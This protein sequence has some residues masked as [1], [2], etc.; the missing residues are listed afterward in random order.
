MSYDAND[1]KISQ[2]ESVW[3]EIKID[4]KSLVTIGV[5]YKSQATPDYELRELFKVL[6]CA[7]HSNV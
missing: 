5:C 6:E 7:S 2:S 1:L 3:F 4:N